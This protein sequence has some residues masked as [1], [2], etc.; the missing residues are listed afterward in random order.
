MRE[1]LP[2]GGHMAKSDLVEFNTNAW[3][4]CPTPP[5]PCVEVLAPNAVVFGG[6]VF[7]R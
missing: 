3:C 1:D 7:G 2:G 5:N 6:G 4:L